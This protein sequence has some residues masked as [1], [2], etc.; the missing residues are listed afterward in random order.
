M[1][2]R[3]KLLSFIYAFLFVFLMFCAP[4]IIDAYDDEHEDP[5]RDK[6]KPIA[7]RAV[8]K[9][10]FQLLSDKRICVGVCKFFQG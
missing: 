9:N 2:M 4:V 1:N 10:V 7:Y 3:I 8:I 6:V 5:H